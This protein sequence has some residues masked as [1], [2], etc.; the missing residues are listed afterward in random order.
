MSAL[1][2]PPD[3]LHASGTGESVFECSVPA[4]STC[5]HPDLHA[6][7]VL[8]GVRIA[9]FLSTGVEDA[10]TGFSDHD[11]AIKAVGL[12]VETGSSVAQILISAKTALSNA[13]PPAEGTLLHTV[14]CGQDPRRHLDCS[15]HTL[16]LVVSYSGHGLFFAGDSRLY[17]PQNL[18]CIGGNVQD[19][20]DI[21]YNAPNTTMADF[22]FPGAVPRLAA[23]GA[24]LDMPPPPKYEARPLREVFRAAATAYPHKIAL[25]DGDRE[26]TYAA[27]DALTDMLADEISE[28]L[29]DYPAT[30]Y[31]A[32]CIPASPLALIV[33][34]AIIKYGAAFV[35][36]DVRLPETRLCTIV[37]NSEANLL[38]TSADSPSVSDVPAA[39]LD[40]SNFLDVHIPR[41]AG[42]QGSAQTLWR[43]QPNEIAYVLHT[44]GTTGVPK[45]VCIRTSTVLAL[46][47]ERDYVLFTSDMRVGQIGNLAWDGS[48]L[49]V[50]CT[51]TIGATLVCFSSYDVLEPTGLAAL[52]RARRVNALS[53]ATSL[54]RHFLSVAPEV[55]ADLRVVMAGGEVLDFSQ[56]QRFRAVNPTGEL[57]NGYGPT[58]TCYIAVAHR[59]GRMLDHGPVPIGKPLC[60]TQCVV[61]DGN[62]R[63]VPPGIPGELF[64]GGRGV[65]AGYLNRPEETSAA[66]VRMA[67]PG[68]DQPPA[69]FYRTGDL[70][71]WLPSGDMQFERRLQSGQIKIRGQRLELAEVESAIVGTR[72][73]KDAAVVYVKPTD[74]RSPYL[75]AFVVP[76]TDGEGVDTLDPRYFIR[77]LKKVVPAYMVPQTVFVRASLP[78]SNSGKLDRHLLGLMAQEHDMADLD[79]GDAAGI[80]EMGAR[81]AIEMKVAD[82]MSAIL[83]GKHIGLEDDFFDVGGHSLLAL[84]LKWGLDKAFGTLVTMQDIFGGAT[85]RRLAELVLKG[86]LV[87]GG[88]DLPVAT[89]ARTLSSTDRHCYIPSPGTRWQ[90]P[91]SHAPPPGEVVSHCP[92][93]LRLSGELSESL[94]ERALQAMTSRQDILRTVFEEMDGSVRARVTDWVP[95]LEIVDAPP[96]KNGQDLEGY[97]RRYASRPFDID[98]T[99]PFRPILFR[100]SPQAFVLLL[101]F[102]HIITDGYS[103]DIIVRELCEY[104]GA[105]CEGRDV[106]LPDLPVTCADVAHWERSDPFGSFIAPQLDYWAAHLQKATAASFAPDLLGADTST[107]LTASDFVPIVLSESLVARLDAACAMSRTTLSMALLAAL[108]VVHFRRTGARD[109]VLGGA[110]A[111]RQRPE[112]AHLQGFFATA[113]LY[114][115]RVEAGQRFRDVLEQMRALV[116]EG[117]SNL[118]AHMSTIAEALWERGAVAAGSMPLRIAMGYVVHEKALV[119]ISGLRM[120]RME[121]NMH[122]VQL[123]MEIYFGR[124]A[125][126]DKVTGEINY[127]RDLY[128]K[129]YIQGL[130]RDLEGILECFVESSDF[131]VN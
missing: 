29:R 115:I 75:A 66:F 39:R 70:V 83:R 102:D 88:S 42:W 46:L 123:D 71:R 65:A 31:I 45:G 48:I 110:T 116:A 100:L 69:T 10:I 52:C 114:R 101:S 62:G 4:A 55:F 124:I 40:V 118:D 23:A 113:L 72:L 50:C 104:Y 47:F 25:T 129:A 36:L 51:L 106:D 103:E 32:T 93:W 79:E 8:A 44:S 74:G 7:I 61:F 109:A 18:R 119:Q 53:I 111:N 91:A 54:F 86:S 108:R 131:L 38:I 13:S 27:F 90:Y 12:H 89:L 5:I 60:Y 58:E 125:R 112:L 77:Q 57:V 2:F 30:D 11:E 26:L 78:L 37:T 15:Q 41:V 33:I 99:P 22:H 82:I 14:V 59:V 95:T 56:C 16:P 35:P 97:L 126:T 128:S 20:I 9:H 17:S 68:L 105:L 49:D 19:V 1:S 127:R 92:F 3:L 85:A 73:A 67:I 81:N 34:Y 107:Y 117:V 120:E 6:V 96:M 130:A 98:T 64:I 21:I 24:L 87:V 76:A 28:A 43:T 121:V 63:L 122:A 94:L 80:N 84:Q